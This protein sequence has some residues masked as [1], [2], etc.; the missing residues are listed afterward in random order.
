MESCAKLEMGALIKFLCQ[1]TSESIVN[2][3]VLQ[4]K[5][6]NVVCP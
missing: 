3:E 6:L 5:N 2:S 4:K 1:N